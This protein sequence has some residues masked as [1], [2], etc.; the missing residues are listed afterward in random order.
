MAMVN[1]FPYAC[2][3]FILFNGALS[4]SSVMSTIVSPLSPPRNFTLGPTSFLLDGEEHYLRSGELHYSRIPSALWEDRL[5]RVKALGLNAVQV[6]VPWNFHERSFVGG[7]YD[8]EGDRD[9]GRFLSLASERGLL[10]LLRPGPY[11]CGEWDFG[12]LPARLLSDQSL[13]IRTYDEAYMSEVTA[14]FD[15]LLPLM[16]P[17]LVE[18]G[19]AIVMVQVENEYG[20]FGD[21]TSNP[22]DEKYLRSLISLVRKHLGESIVLYTTDGGNLAAMQRGSLEGDIVLSLGDFGPGSDITNAIKGQQAMNPADKNPLMCSEY[23]TGWLTHWGEDLQVTD[24]GT[25]IGTMKEMLA[26]N[27]SFN[28]YMAHGGTSFGF[29]AGANGDGALDY[30]SDITSYDYNCPISESGSHNFGSDGVD[31]FEAIQSLMRDSFDDATFDEPEPRPSEAFNSIP[32]SKYSSGSLIEI[33]KSID[34]VATGAVRRVEELN[35]RFGFTLYTF[36]VGSCTGPCEVKLDKIRDRA[37]VYVDGLYLVDSYRTDNDDDSFSFEVD[38]DD[39][40]AVVDVL[41]VNLGRIGFGHAVDWKGLDDIVIKGESLSEVEHR[42]L[43]MTTDDLENIDMKKFE[44]DSLG[45]RFYEGEL[46]VKDSGVASTHLDMSSWGSGF[47]WVNDFAL[48][49]YWSDM[50]PTLSLWI[51]DSYLQ[52]GVNSIV[53][54]ELQEGAV[55][56]CHKELVFSSKPILK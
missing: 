27:M 56:D 32:L 20:S 33:M 3:L 40:S 44:G 22:D 31:K 14:W 53:V 7:E 29:W 15:V 11:I 9:I 45:Q 30:L 10:V 43:E 2:V 47:V 18:N 17:F 1:M 52:K 39:S 25:M 24:T 19:G 23:Y 6:Y 26:A 13:K 4:S 8:F 54:L 48:G 49:R 34:P 16:Q 28:L 41:V 55:E 50:G 12:G 36:P 38:V 5:D 37:F 21:V 42:T 51:P 35:Q 46:E